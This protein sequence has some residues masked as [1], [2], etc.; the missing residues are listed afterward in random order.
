MTLYEFFGDGCPHCEKMAPKVDQ[1]EE[2]EDVE[3]EQLEVW[4]NQENAEKQ[5]EL[6]DGKCGGVPFFYNTESEEW[7]CGETELDTL[8]DWADSRE[9]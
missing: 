5:K 7:I 3:V 6:D 1:L 9:V 8:K 4:N 2:E